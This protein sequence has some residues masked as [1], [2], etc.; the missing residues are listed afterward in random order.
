MESQPQIGHELVVEAL[1]DIVVFPIRRN[2]SGT[3]RNATPAGSGR[4]SSSASTSTGAGRSSGSAAT[5]TST[6]HSAARSRFYTR[7]FVVEAL[8][9]D[10]A[11]DEI[12]I[13]GPVIYYSD[14]TNTRTR[15]ASHIPR[16][17]IFAPRRRPA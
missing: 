12:T 3:Y 2:V 6:S 9:I 1:K 8:T 17:R 5:S 13:S 15:S 4:S 7:S 11:A 14:P 10:S 16:V